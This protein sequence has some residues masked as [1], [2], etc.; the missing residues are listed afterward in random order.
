MS[1]T[2]EDEQRSLQSDLDQE[3]AVV[4]LDQ[5]IADREQA[6]VDREQEPLDAA[7]S[8]LAN[9]VPDIGGDHR[10]R[11][12]R[13]VD[14]GLQQDRQDAHQ[15]QI[16]QTQL[17]QGVRQDVLDQQQIDLEVNEPAHGG[18]EDDQARAG[19]ELQEALRLRAKETLARA[20]AAR[21][22]AADT[23]LRLEAAHARQLQR[24]EREG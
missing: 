11:A 2:T 23:L 14:I 22:R 21:Q 19:E 10:S 9:T 18:G 4:D 15:A 7:A 20:E 1:K 24:Q 3:Q 17:A 6:R 12:E 5:G 16:D 8:A 13:S